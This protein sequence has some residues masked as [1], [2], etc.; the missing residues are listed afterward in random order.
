MA[1]ENKPTPPPTPFNEANV[2]PEIEETEHESIRELRDVPIE[3][4]PDSKL[5][6]PAEAVKD[7]ETP[8]ER[9][10]RRE[11]EAEL[12]KPIEALED[13]VNRL[14]QEDQAIAT[15]IA[16]VLP[17]AM[18]GTTELFG[19]TLP[20]PIYTVVYGTL[21]ALTLTEV[22]IASLP[23]GWFGNALLIGMSGIKAALV[24]TFYMHLRE[25]S[26]V[27]LLVLV[28]PMIIAIVAS[29]FLLTVPHTGY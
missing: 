2:P 24:V 19:Y 28:L 8:D 4:V 18:S 12:N 14:D 23:H 13:A 26:R 1:E 9:A 27:F 11:G 25:D 6:E 3:T 15:D 7:A 21:V 10:A 17:H 16:H 29:L 22:I 20:F 5:P